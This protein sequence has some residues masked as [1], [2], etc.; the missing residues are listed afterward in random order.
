MPNTIDSNVSQ[1]R[2]CEEDSFGVVSGDEVWYPL[3][4]NSYGD[5][6]P[7]IGT[8][9]RAPITSDRQNRKGVTTDLDASGSFNIDLTQSNLTRLIQG[10]FFAD[11][12]EKGTTVPLNSAAVVVS[13]VDGTNEDFETAG[14]FFTTIVGH[15]V[16]AEGFTNAANNGVHEVTTG[17]TTTSIPVLSNLVTETP[18]ATATLKLVGYEFGDA[19]VNVNATGGAFPRL[20]RAS[21]SVNWTTIGIQA[22]DWIWIGGDLAANRFVNAAN[23]GWARVRSIAADSMTI[24]KSQGTMVDET[25]TDLTV[26]VYFGDRINNDPLG[27]EGSVYNRRS[28]QLERT[29]GDDGVDTQAEYL[30][31]AIPN[32]MTITISTADKITVDMAFVAKDASTVTGTVGVKGGTRPTLA[33]TDAFN[34]TSHVP[35][36]RMGLRSNIDSN[37][38][39][40]FAY[41][42]ELSLTI[43]NNVSPIK[44]V[45]NLG[46]VEMTSG[47]FAVTGNATAF[48]NTVGAQAA[49]RNN[50]DVDI[51]AG[52]VRNNAGF[53][54]DVPLLSLGDGQLDVALNEPITLPLEVMGAKDTTY[55]YSASF[56]VFHY[57][58]DVAESTV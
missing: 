27:S 54:L 26:R 46:A 13:A 48:F 58:P 5:F 8:T 41:L 15:L 36:M 21:G 20:E 24:D 55:S 14:T 45:A 28:Y 53:M 4:P 33:D 12:A 25:G 37:P 43:G 10:F 3:D 11:I 1:L 49:V 40:L 18:P 52:L 38:G 42:S 35:F 6:G 2:Y 22:G 44:A 51:C 32:E 47:N 57:L 30:E 34:T 23:N 7:Q 29:L 56:T 31:G 16:L 50:S 9:A 19:R 17:P 39:S